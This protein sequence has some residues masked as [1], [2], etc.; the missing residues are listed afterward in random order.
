VVVHDDEWCRRGLVDGVE[1]LGGVLSTQAALDQKGALAFDD[2]AAIDVVLVEA[3]GGSA[4]WDRFAGLGVAEAIRKQSPLPSTVVTLLVNDPCTDLLVLRAAE[5]GADF[6]Y[7]HSAIADLE[8]LERLLLTPDLARTPGRT[9]DHQTLRRF[10]LSYSS[11]LNA[12]LAF[13]QEH[14]LS[15]VFSDGGIQRLSRRQ[16]ITTRHRVSEIM[17]VRPV[18][19]VTGTTVEPSMPSWRQLKEIVDLAR[20]ASLVPG[21]RLAPDTSLGSTWR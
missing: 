11:R 19:P 2:W 17:R 13:I 14:G 18:G 9:V 3:T 8:Q 10:G 16:S 15:S 5:A 1:E 6:V 20:G 21:N 4:G 7:P 12:A